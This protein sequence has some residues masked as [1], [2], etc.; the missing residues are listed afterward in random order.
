[1]LL[2]ITMI[3]TDTTA[4]KIIGK[5][6]LDCNDSYI[7]TYDLKHYG[8][9]TYLTFLGNDSMFVDD[10][11]TFV[12]KGIWESAFYYKFDKN[13]NIVHKGEFSSVAAHYAPIDIY[14]HSGVVY[15][16]LKGGGDLYYNGEKVATQ[17]INIVHTYKENYLIVGVDEKTDEVVFVKGMEHGDENGFEAIGFFEDR[18]Y[19]GGVINGDSILLDS[20]A[21]H[22]Y[23]P[24][25][26]CITGFLATYDLTTGALIN[27]SRFG[28]AGYEKMHEM[29]IDSKGNV[30][31]LTTNGIAA[32]IHINEEELAWLSRCG[33]SSIIHKYDKDGRFLT[34]RTQ[35]IFDC[36]YTWHSS[37]VMLP[38]DRIA[39]AGQIFGNYKV[40]DGEIDTL[41]YPYSREVTVLDQDLNVAWYDYYSVEVWPDFPLL[42]IDDSGSIYTSFVNIDYGGGIKGKEGDVTKRGNYLIKYAEDGRKDYIRILDSEDRVEQMEAIGQDTLLIYLQT[43]PGKYSPLIGDTARFHETYLVYLDLSVSTSVLDIDNKMFTDDMSLFPNP[44]LRGDLVH[45]SGSNIPVSCDVYNMMGSLQLNVKIDDEA[46]ALVDTNVL[47][48]GMYIVKMTYKDKRIVS[49]KLVVLE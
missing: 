13:Q 35:S 44:V 4:Q 41:P 36:S 2:C 17:Q 24:G 42:T 15:F 43:Q 8:E 46:S 16:C 49:K 1:M 18:M 9:F 45:V 5:T 21:I 32:Q 48:E 33:G 25:E 19:L 20:K 12:D 38:D 26:E 28:A 3:C 27:T 29:Q 34:Y 23:C 47:A 22:S 30:Y 11:F 7:T 31:L 37:M 10:K 14:Y 6:K 40:S 39:I